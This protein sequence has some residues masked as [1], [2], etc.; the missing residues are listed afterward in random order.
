MQA[1]R[2]HLLNMVTFGPNQFSE[3]HLSLAL[4]VFW[5]LTNDAHNSPPANNL[6]FHTNGF[7]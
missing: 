4:F 5:I 2:W 3:V 1:I 6:A 7:Y